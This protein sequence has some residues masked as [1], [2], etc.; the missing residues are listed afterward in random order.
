[1]PQCSSCKLHKRTCTYAR[2][3][4]GRA[5][6]AESREVFARAPGDI[7]YATI[8]FLDPEMFERSSLWPL[9]NTVRAP[10]H[11][12]D[13]LGDTHEIR[14]VVTLFFQNVHPW[15]PIVA[16][17]RFKDEILN[18]L[19][20]PRADLCFL[21]LCMKLLAEPPTDIGEAR[22]DSAYQYAKQL[23][24]DL[25]LE[26][27]LSLEFL[28]AHILLALYE[29]GQGIY[30]ATHIS[31]GCCLK[32]AAALGMS[33]E[34]PSPMLPQRTWTDA[35]E[36]R[37]V[38]WSIFILE[39][40]TNLS[41]PRQ[42]LMCPEPR[43]TAPLPQQESLW[44]N[45]KHNSIAPPLLSSP[46]ELLGRFA[47]VAQASYLL[48]RVYRHLSDTLLPESYYEETQQLNRTIHALIQYLEINKGTT[49]SAACYQTAL[50]YCALITLHSQYLP[51]LEP[52][53]YNDE[54]QERAIKALDEAAGAAFVT[55][56]KFLDTDKIDPRHGEIPPFIF[57][58]LYKSS[59]YYIQRY[60]VDKSDDLKY[61][62]ATLEQAL[63]Y[64]STRWK[65]A[66]DYLKLLAAHS[67][68]S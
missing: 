29:L 21:C 31:V 48:S 2:P 4:A 61:R 30:P 67:L 13:Y 60:N 56:R 36:Q 55:M 10:K 49:T 65:S 1:M 53:M 23:C 32:Y 25:Q 27:V 24:H 47:G 51:S 28:Q 57:P 40:V 8:R 19:I 14:K 46:P 17:R 68:M 7:S 35:E 58:W 38:W 54:I 66:A 11:L 9:Q 20:P 12:H 26:N 45:E 3:V 50:S 52:E 43:P 37:R 63:R 18:P 16:K 59:M 15:F 42:T 41:H 39:R 44:D 34:A 64:F 33:W 6:P 22:M 62:I 5:A